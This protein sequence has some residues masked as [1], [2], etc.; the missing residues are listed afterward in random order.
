MGRI[1]HRAEG[2]VHQFIRLVGVVNLLGDLAQHFVVLAVAP[3]V[4]ARAVDRLHVVDQSFQDLIVG[5]VVEA[6]LVDV[7]FEVAHALTSTVVSP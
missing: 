1:F 7:G 5:G 3:Q 4:H 6:G 2:V